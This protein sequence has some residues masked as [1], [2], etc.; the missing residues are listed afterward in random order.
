MSAAKMVT[1]SLKI[2]TRSL[3]SSVVTL[4]V[5]FI[6]SL[7]K[8]TPTTKISSIIFLVQSVGFLI[9]DMAR[10]ITQFDAV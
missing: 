3:G 9:T 2:L 8:F 1:P 4:V 7:C 5:A 6:L 10:A